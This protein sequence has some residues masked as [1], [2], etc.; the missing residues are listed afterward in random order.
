MG[1]PSNWERPLVQQWTATGNLA[2]YKYF[3]TRK[4]VVDFERANLVLR[5]R[6]LLLGDNASII[7]TPGAELTDLSEL[8]NTI[9]NISCEEMVTRDSPPVMLRV[10]F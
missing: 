8:I 7:V 4:R 10:L 3:D 6:S 2:G 9:V 1:K 5:D